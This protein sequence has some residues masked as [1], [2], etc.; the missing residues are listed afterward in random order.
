MRGTRGCRLA[1]GLVFLGV[2]AGCR[3]LPGP[4]ALLDGGLVS[5]PPL[6]PDRE[7]AAMAHAFFS[8]GIHHELADRYDLATEAYRRAAEFDPASEHL[9]LRMASTLV[10]QRQIDEALRTVE[11]FLEHHPASESILLWLATCYGT[12]GNQDRVLDLFRRMTLEFPEKPEGWLQLAAAMARADNPDPDAILRTL[13]DGLA[14]ARPPNVLRQELVRLYLNREKAA[15]TET[16]RRDIRQKA[17]ALLRQSAEEQ[18]GDSETL[19]ALG[20]LLVQDEQL[21]DAVQ[22]YEKIE[23]LHPA[24]L[25]VKQRLARTFLAMDDQAKAIALL[26][27]LARNRSGPANASYYLAELYLQAGDLPNASRQFRAAAEAMPNDPAPWLK[28]AALQSDRNPEAAVATLSEALAQMPGDPKLLEV[29]ALVRLHQKRYSQ[30]ADLFQQVW[31]SA[32]AASPDLIPSNLFFYNFAITCTHLRRTDEAA[33]WLRRAMDQDPALLE[34]YMQRTMTG[35]SRFR[36]SATAVL[37]TLSIRPGTE[38]AS[39]HAHLATLLLSREKPEQA[40]RE[41]DKALALARTDPLRS[42]PLTARFYFWFGVA[43][44]QAGQTDRAVEM[45]ETCIRL[46]PDHA[47]A[48]NYLAYLWAGRAIRL[49]EALRHI[50]AALVIDPENAAYLDTLGWVFHQ[51]GRYAEALDFLQQA[52]RLQPNDPEIREHLEKTLEKLESPPDSP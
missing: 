35:T 15:R 45:F 9:V 34:L 12:T 30:A 19:Y 47:D 48:L 4:P 16:D 43:L 13:E 46:D 26:E 38:G 3:S 23:R 42:N 44:D 20:D 2:A 41:F 6:P 21:A 40:I 52:D 49:D 5:S 22:V 18:P 28:L 8:I 25:Q 37:R 17:I 39:I 33:T 24:D 7:R 50:Q 27:E 10:M 11:T 1:L 36:Q 32:T 31:D 51:L 14:R 29:L